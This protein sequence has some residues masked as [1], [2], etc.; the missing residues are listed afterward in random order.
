MKKTV[1][2]S[3]FSYRKVERNISQIGPK[4]YR[5]RVVNFDGYSPTRNEARTLRK[6]FLSKLG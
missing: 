3:H 5:V 1:N 6:T 2:T 4:T